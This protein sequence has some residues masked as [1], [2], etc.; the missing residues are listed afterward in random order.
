MR[1]RKA[2]SLVFILMLAAA[3]I[4]GCASKG[5]PAKVMENTGGDS[6]GQAMP[7]GSESDGNQAADDSGSM[8]EKDE[9][10]M[11]DDKGI[12]ENESEK[13]SS[14]DSADDDFR[15]IDEALDY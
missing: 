10:A 1:I 5:E 3:I 2:I 8:M 14:L 15:G 7:A 9:P 11:E 4:T 12:M 6:E 13:S